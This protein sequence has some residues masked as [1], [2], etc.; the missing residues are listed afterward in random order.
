MRASLS[1]TPAILTLTSTLPYPPLSS[2]SPRR[3]PPPAPRPPT[4]PTSTSTRR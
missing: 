4:T 1:L 3:P 2:L